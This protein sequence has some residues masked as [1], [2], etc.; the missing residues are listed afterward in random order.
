MARDREEVNDRATDQKDR[1]VDPRH[2]FSVR[3]PDEPRCGRR[4]RRS[5][6]GPPL[7]RLTEP[8]QLLQRVAEQ[9]SPTGALHH[10]R[11]RGLSPPSPAGVIFLLLFFRCDLILGE[12]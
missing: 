8:V 10:L 1:D 11:A 2:L 7:W 3:H 12:N 4:H 9:L 5:R 6:V